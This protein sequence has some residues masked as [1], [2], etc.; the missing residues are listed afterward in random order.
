M[1]NGIINSGPRAPFGFD[2]DL[3]SGWMWK[4]DSAVYVSMITSL[5]PGKGNFRRL[6]YNILS[7]GYT[8]KIPTPMGR[9]IDI[10]KKCGYKPKIENTIHGNCQ[11]WVL[12]KERIPHGQSRATN[13]VDR[14][15]RTGPTLPGWS[16]ARQE[17]RAD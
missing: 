15:P 3:F 14:V 4:I 2:S 10:L 5:H 12:K 17:C 13:P 9:M 6:I 7:A 16:D 1:K 8:V 11:V